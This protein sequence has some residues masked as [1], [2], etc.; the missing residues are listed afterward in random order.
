MRNRQNPTKSD[1]IKK[2]KNNNEARAKQ[3]KSKTDKEKVC[4]FSNFLGQKPNTIKKKKHTK[5]NTIKKG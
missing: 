1:T 4:V 5:S 3:E 2:G